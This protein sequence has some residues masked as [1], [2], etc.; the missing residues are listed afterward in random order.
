MPRR[1]LFTS[2]TVLWSLLQLCAPV[3]LG[4]VNLSGD[5]VDWAHFNPYKSNLGRQLVPNPYLT[6]RNANLYKKGPAFPQD[7]TRTN[8]IFGRGVKSLPT[9]IYAKTFDILLI[10]NKLY[11][12]PAAGE[13]KYM[14]I[15][16]QSLTIYGTSLYTPLLDNR[17]V[18]N[19]AQI[20]PFDPSRVFYKENKTLPSV[21][22]AEP[23]KTIT[24]SN[25]SFTVPPAGKSVV[26]IV[27]ADGHIKVQENDKS[28]SQGQSQSNNPQAMIDHYSNS[29]GGKSSAGSS[30]K[31]TGATSSA[32]TKDSNEK[33]AL[34][35]TNSSSSD[36]AAS[37]N[38]PSAVTSSS[39]TAKTAAASNVSSQSSSVSASSPTQASSTSSSSKPTQ[40]SSTSSNSTQAN[41]ISSSGIPANL[42][43]INNASPSG[44]TNKTASSAQATIS[45]G[46]SGSSSSSIGKTA[47]TSG[48]SIGAPS[49]VSV[50][51]GGSPSGVSSRAVGVSSGAFGSS[52]ASKGSTVGASSGTSGSTAGRGTAGASS[53]T[54]G[55]G[56]A[57]ST[58]GDTTSSANYSGA[59]PLKGNVQ[60]DNPGSIYEPGKLLSKAEI[61]D[62]T[63]KM[64]QGQAT[65][66]RQNQTL[67]GQRCLYKPESWTNLG[68]IKI[69]LV[70]MGSPIIPGQT[71]TPNNT[72]DFHAVQGQYSIN[73][74]VPTGKALGEIGQKV[75]FHVTYAMDKNNY[76]YTWPNN[77]DLAAVPLS[78]ELVSTLYPM[79][80]ASPPPTR[81]APKEDLSQY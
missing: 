15:N 57:T 72:G 14:Q 31:S 71:I 53:G 22:Y 54:S 81:N 4:E 63:N 8:L 3:V 73:P 34:S 77:T 62:Q 38:K 29:Q 79:T 74:P 27:S 78:P 23:G 55:M 61:I 64:L 46:S 50:S 69:T 75:T 32:D 56:G 45:A 28:Q 12:A 49:G 42:T 43:A 21:V 33:T 35:P 41:N 39:T 2:M 40:I 68:T 13:S 17:F 19:P 60:Q 10:G 67:T 30:T 20:H 5:A 59:E 47:G 25:Q 52:P 80:K 76:T 70:W 51:S 66:G 9:V 36:T 16:G 37:K 6:S 44:T 18:A 48:G 11:Q 7:P 24:I 58:Q 65:I 1:K 26:L